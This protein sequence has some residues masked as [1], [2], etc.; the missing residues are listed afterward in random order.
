MTL[1]ARLI[2]VLRWSRGQFREGAIRQILEMRRQLSH[3][4]HRAESYSTGL[5]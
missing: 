2:L 5:R 4:R 1:P 3:L